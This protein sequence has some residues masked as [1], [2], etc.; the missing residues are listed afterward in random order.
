MPLGPGTINAIISAL[1]D[2]TH[3]TAAALTPYGEALTGP[4]A[5]LFAVTTGIA[6]ANGNANLVAPLM[7]WTGAC[8][9]TFYALWQWPQITDDTLAGS[10]QVVGLLTGG[11]DGPATL[12]RTANDV[13]VRCFAETNGASM[14]SPWTYWQV[15]LC[16]I[17]GILVWLGLA[18][19]GLLAILAEFQL[20]VG[21]ACV[22]LV[23]PAL[24]FP[25][26]MPIGWGGV[27][28]MASAGLRVIILGATSHYM[29]NAVTQVL[30][31]A[32]T[33][34]HLTGEQLMTLLGI[35]CLTALAGF[36][37][38]G[39]ARD[40]ISGAVGTLGLSS[41]AGTAGMVIGGARI[42]G[43]A[44]ASVGYGALGAGGLAAKGGHALYSTMSSGRSGGGGGGGGG[45]VTQSSGKGSAFGRGG[46]TGTQPAFGGA[47]ASVPKVG[48]A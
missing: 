41:I 12:F 26:T 10:R 24:A 21:A 27:T 3:G 17:V 30:S 33:D 42:A 4:F 47:T 14:L 48:L 19:T 40:L 36:T 38:N 23:L 45:R 39:I 15:F 11:Y 31:L 1:A 7:R 25:V 46:T 13:A 5:V 2:Q 37:M 8:A 35:G 32:G 18:M 43:G 29:A 9:L 20:V 22:P 34:H 44:A 16:D 28:F 6:W